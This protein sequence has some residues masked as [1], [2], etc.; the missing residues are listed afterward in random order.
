[1]F[2]TIYN[3]NSMST[4]NLQNVTFC[5]VIPSLI[6]RNPRVWMCSVQIS[7]LVVT[8]PSHLSWVLHTSSCH[9]FLSFIMGFAR[10]MLSHFPRI[11]HGFCVHHIV[12]A[13]YHD[14]HYCNVD[15]IKSIM[16]YTTLILYYHTSKLTL[17][18]SIISCAFWLPQA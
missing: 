3:L 15:F 8:F 18:T 5:N 2:V 7:L 9:F 13:I 12:I 16:L 4:P 17:Q 10:I 6:S 1:M 11:Y 14:R